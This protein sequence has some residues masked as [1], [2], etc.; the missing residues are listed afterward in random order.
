MS[1]QP[2]TSDNGD[3][4]AV[5]FMPALRKELGL[6]LSPPT[7]ALVLTE[8]GIAE[9]GTHDVLMAAGGLYAALHAVQASI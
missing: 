9:Q 3:R 6:R 1:D 8:D 4:V 5:P 2:N 7:T